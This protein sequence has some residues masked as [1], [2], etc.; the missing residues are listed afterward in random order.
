MPII[1]KKVQGRRQVRYASLDELLADAQRISE[2]GFRKLGNWSPGQIYEHLARSMDASIDGFAFS[3]PAPVRWMMSLLM[4]NKMLYNSVPP[5]YKAPA[6]YTPEETSTEA[7][8]ASLKKSIERQESETS[9]V[10]H[11]GF[12]NLSLEEWEAFNLRH[13][14]M[15]MSFLVEVEDAGS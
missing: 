3:M 8:L 4:K 9:R 1:T 14:E 2:N 12:G 11:P 7:G 10:I 13:A 15:H 6:K 5:G